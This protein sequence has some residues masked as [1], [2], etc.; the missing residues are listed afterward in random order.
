MVSDTTHRWVNNVALSTFIVIGL[1]FAVSW[2]ETDSGGLGMGAL[3][4]LPIIL[5][6]LLAGPFIVNIIS[7]RILSSRLDSVIYRK[8][9]VTIWIIATICMIVVYIFTWNG[10]RNFYK[11]KNTEKSILK[12]AQESAQGA[13]LVS[14]CSSI[15]NINNNGNNYWELLDVWKSCIQQTLTSP[16]DIPEC[17]QQ[18][19]LFTDNMNY[20]SEQICVVH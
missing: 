16:V 10:L 2:S 18:G 12:T 9:L 4:L 11:N 14:D 7:W 20:I 8:R 6:S 3:V 17:T 5:I 19:R 15:A 1:A 13:K